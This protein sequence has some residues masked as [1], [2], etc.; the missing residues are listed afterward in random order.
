MVILFRYC[1]I[2]TWAPY[3]L[4][5]ICPWP[6]A[7]LLWRK[8]VLAWFLDSLWTDNVVTDNTHGHWQIQHWMGWCVHHWQ[9]PYTWQQ[10]PD[11]R[12]PAATSN[13]R[14]PILVNNNLYHSCWLNEA[15]ISTYVYAKTSVTKYLHYIP[16]CIVL[17]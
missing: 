2:D 5:Y 9:H 11:M 8:M 14:F 15:L 3:V 12:N 13:R 6:L 16:Y 10:S 1:R 17:N 7:S 4:S